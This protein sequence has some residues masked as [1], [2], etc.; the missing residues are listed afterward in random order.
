MELI[1]GVDFL[2]YTRGDPARIRSAIRQL[3]AGVH[4]LH[5]A[6]KLHR[7]LKPSNVLVDR[8]GVVRICDFGLAIDLAERRDAPVAGTPRYISPEQVSGAAVDEATDW[9]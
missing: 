5:R 9:Y 6:G 2:T 8:D 3:A 1:D 4:A 7:D